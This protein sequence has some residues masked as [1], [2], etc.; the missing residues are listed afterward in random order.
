MLQKFLQP[1]NVVFTG[2]GLSMLPNHLYQ[3]VAGRPYMTLEE[4]MKLTK[5]PELLSSMFW[6]EDF[7]FVRTP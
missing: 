6:N 4:V 2:L 5:D 7:Y 1:Q 3:Q